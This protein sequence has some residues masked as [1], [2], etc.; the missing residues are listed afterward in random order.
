MKNEYQIK[1]IIDLFFILAAIAGCLASIIVGS[2]NVADANDINNAAG[3]NL[4]NTAWYWIEIF[5]M[6]FIYAGAAF[7]IDIIIKRILFI[8]QKNNQN[9]EKISN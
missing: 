4:I 3:F 8:D 2:M 6:P 5:L 7:I 1:K 9:K